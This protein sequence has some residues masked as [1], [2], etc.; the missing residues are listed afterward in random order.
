MLRLS[1][2]FDPFMPYSG[3]FALLFMQ[4]VI[5]IILALQDNQNKD[6]FD[7]PLERMET[8]VKIKKEKKNIYIYLD[9]VKVAPIVLSTKY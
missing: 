3:T 1:L 6:S 5:Q 9:K 4:I 2:N 7:L 8:K